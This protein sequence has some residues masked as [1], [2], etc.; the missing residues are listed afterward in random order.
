MPQQ[1]LRAHS[2][3]V[4][5][6]VTQ[7][8]IGRF[9]HF[10]L[11]RQLEKHGLLEAIYTGYPRF[12]LKDEHGIPSDKI[13]TFP[14][15]QAPFMFRN[16]I[17]LDK[18]EWL[19]NEW[20]WQANDTLDR[21][22]ARN[23]KDNNIL[24]ALSGSG[25]H[26]GK[27]AKK[28]GGKH[29]C[30]RGSSHIRFQNE[31]LRDEFERWKMPYREIDQRTIAK[32]E[33]E[34]EQA[35]KITVPSDFVRNSFLNKGVPAEKLVKVVYGARLDRFSKQGDPDPSKFVV[36][37]VGT[38]SLRKGFMYL[39]SAFQKLKHAKKELQVIGPVSEEMHALLKTASLAGVK[40]VGAVANAEL[41][42]MYSTAHVFVLPSLEEGLAMVQGEALACG[43][44]VIGSTNSG[45][46]DLITHGKEG[47]IVPIRS[48]EAILESLQRLADEKF[49]REQMSE[50][51]LK[52]VKT[53]GGWDV[54]GNNYAALIKAF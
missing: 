29:I 27:S 31:I 9:H 24:V 42:K 13:K 26:A 12:K 51:A 45:A 38:V 15:L 17:G 19:N 41:S 52:C 37:W 32:E 18:W 28:L 16:R 7:I 46:E 1:V 33:A 40:F 8:S 49:L 20:A 48:P 6:N 35:D 11:A 43:C 34:Y 23:I 3:I 2:S 5:M 44:P 21:H 54:Y 22:V 14:W 4:S 10:H 25:L 50:E 53:I 36:L 47:F 30:D 39:L